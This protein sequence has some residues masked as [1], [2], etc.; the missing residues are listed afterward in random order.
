MKTLTRTPHSALPRAVFCDHRL[1]CITTTC[2]SIVF[3]KSH[4]LIPYAPL[5]P[6]LMSWA[7]QC[8]KALPATFLSFFGPKLWC[9]LLSHS[10]SPHSAPLVGHASSEHHH[11]CP[12][13]VMTTCPSRFTFFFSPDSSPLSKSSSWMN[14][15]ISYTHCSLLFLLYLVFGSSFCHPLF[16]PCWPRQSSHPSPTLPVPS[17]CHAYV[18]NAK[19]CPSVSICVTASV[20]SR[21]SSHFLSPSELLYILRIPNCSWDHPHSLFSLFIFPP[22][23]ISLKYTISISLFT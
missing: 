21:P 12:A 8:F 6:S 16:L 2:H 9:P 17:H 10:L 11:P 1:Y 7:Q 13:P 22:F 19:I 14:L 15:S 5:S 23:S 18:S 4:P 20:F 3:L